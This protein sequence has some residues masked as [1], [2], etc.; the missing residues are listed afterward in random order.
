MTVVVVIITLACV[1]TSTI[2]FIIC[3]ARQAHDVNGF[4]E[5]DGIQVSRDGRPCLSL[6]WLYK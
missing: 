1:N 6:A 4:S 3:C 2:S 5:S